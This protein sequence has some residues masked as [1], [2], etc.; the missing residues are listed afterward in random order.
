MAGTH[1]IIRFTGHVG[2]VTLYSGT[3]QLLLN[4]TCKMEWKTALVVKKNNLLSHFVRSSDLLLMLGVPKLL[5]LILSINRR[6]QQDLQVCSRWSGTQSCQ[7]CD[8]Q[9]HVWESLS[10]ESAGLLKFS[11]LP[12][13]Q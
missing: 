2:E 1:I 12:G 13:R 4:F 8:T 3:L 5:N 7:G 6:T 11:H 10:S 9:V